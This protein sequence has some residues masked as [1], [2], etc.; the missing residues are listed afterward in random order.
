[1][2]IPL[3]HRLPGRSSCQPGPWA[4]ASLW[5]SPS[6]RTDL[7]TQGPYSALLRV[8]LAIPSRLPGPWWALTPPFH[9]HR[10]WMSGPKP[11]TPRQ[12]LLCGAFPEVALAGGYPAPLLHGV[13]TF[14]E[15]HPPRSSSHPREGWHR[16][17]RVRGQWGQ[18]CTRA[19]L[20]YFIN[21]RG[22]RIFIYPLLGISGPASPKSRVYFP[23]AVPSRTVLGPK[24]EAWPH[25]PKAGSG[26]PRPSH[27]HWHKYPLE[28]Q[29]RV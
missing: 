5:R 12:T 27:S 17:K 3:P 8:G 22:L 18:D 14:L 23:S 21:Y 1:M 7:S 9:H 26:R 2:T 25:G 13:R 20:A 16:R 15:G 19:I 28:G 29:G 4:E 10:G 24:G 6:N 11:E